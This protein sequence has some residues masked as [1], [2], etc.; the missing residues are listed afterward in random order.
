MRQLEE[1][2]GVRLPHR[3]TRSVLVTDAGQRLFDRCCSMVATASRFR[4]DLA[5][6]ALTPPR[7]L[8]ACVSEDRSTYE[9][10]QVH[11][12]KQFVVNLAAFSL[13][14][15]C[16]SPSIASPKGVEGEALGARG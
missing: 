13:A 14:K 11:A 8:R 1:R 7:A 15:E 10:T 3:T 4:A 5:Q 9:I 2:L 16:G 12:N 6:A